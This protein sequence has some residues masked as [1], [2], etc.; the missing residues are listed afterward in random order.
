MIQIKSVER[1]MEYLIKVAMR[2]P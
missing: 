2:S 1:Q